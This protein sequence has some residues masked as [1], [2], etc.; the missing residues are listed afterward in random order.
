M[1]IKFSKAATILLL[2]VASFFGLYL[3]GYL[4]DY[5]SSISLGMAKVFFIAL[6]LVVLAAFLVTRIINRHSLGRG[7]LSVT[8]KTVRVAF[9][10]PVSLLVVYLGWYFAVMR[11]D[12]EYLF[13]LKHALTSGPHYAP[14]IIVGGTIWSFIILW[15]IVLVWSVAVWIVKRLREKRRT[16]DA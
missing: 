1:K 4:S 15:L 16:V 5:P 8:T 12:L 7:D 11:G 3:F 14:S 9:L 2:M 10:L 6:W 13:V